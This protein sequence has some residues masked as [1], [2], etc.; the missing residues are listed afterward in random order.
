MFVIHFI[1][2]YNKE[3]QRQVINNYAASGFYRFFKVKHFENWN[4]TKLSPKFIQGSVHNRIYEALCQIYNPLVRVLKRQQ[5]TKCVSSKEPYRFPTNFALIE[6]KNRLLKLNGLVTNAIISL[7]FNQYDQT[8][9]YVLNYNLIS[10]F[11][12]ANARLV[13]IV[14]YLL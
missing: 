7:T 8:I 13:F 14:D 6:S 12:H 1:V 3:L 5:N 9:S 11:L 4:K 10:S 2:K